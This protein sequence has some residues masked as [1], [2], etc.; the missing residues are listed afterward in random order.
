MPMTAEEKK[1][2]AV[3]TLRALFNYDRKVA[4]EHLAPQVQW[5]SPRSL[6]AS[7]GAIGSRQALLELLFTEMPKAYPNGLQDEILATFCEGDTVTIEFTRAGKVASGKDYFGE[8][9]LVCR[10]EGRQIVAA[11]EYCDTLAVVRAISP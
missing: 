6:S 2:I 11:R 4:E 1:H 5:H 9:C 8:Y 7:G 3:A 10:F